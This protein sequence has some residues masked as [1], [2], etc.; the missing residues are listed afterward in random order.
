ME[1]RLHTRH[2]RRHFIRTAA[3]LLVPASALATIPIPL[4]FWKVPSVISSG[5]SVLPSDFTGLQVW[6]RSSD[7]ALNDGDPVATWTDRSSNANN[8]TASGSARPTFKTNIIGSTPVLR[9]DGSANGLFI[10]SCWPLFWW[11]PFQR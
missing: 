6:Y 1:C 4:G 3:G 2:S 7:L 8:S 9:F 10:G 11:C 5:P